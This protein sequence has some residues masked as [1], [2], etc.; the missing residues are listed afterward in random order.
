M[1][2]MHTP[3]LKSS[4][5]RLRTVALAEQSKKRESRGNMELRDG[6]PGLDGYRP[7]PQE[8]Y[9]AFYLP[10]DVRGSVELHT[11]RRSL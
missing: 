6:G 7:W 3:E 1:Q 2:A 11:G 10:L 8:K 5:E 9:Y 4:A